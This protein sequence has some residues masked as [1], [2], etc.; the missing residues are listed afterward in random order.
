M[1]IF[2]LCLKTLMLSSFW[3][4]ANSAQAE[5]LSPDTKIL[6]QQEVEKGIQKFMQGELFNQRVESGIN[7]YIDKQKQQASDQKRQKNEMGNNARKV[8]PKVDH[9]RGNAQA[10]YTLIEY[11]DFECPYCKRFH[12]TAQKFID[13][14]TDVNW[15]FRN[16]PLSFHGKVAQREAEAAECAAELGG[17][18]TYWKYDDG[19]FNRTLT[20]GRGIPNGGIAKLA[21]D[22]GLEKTAFLDC[23]DSGK[24]K[25]F[26]I[27]Q[28]EDGNNAGVSGTPGNLLRHNP[29]GLTIPVHGAQPL[30]QL[31]AAL[32]ALRRQVNAKNE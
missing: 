12:P 10:N 30:E 31:Q 17:N 15:V 18:D 2:F 27:A 25:D 16:Y 1:K 32:E 9:I 19:Q 21:E 20:N 24:F 6:I 29:S 11:S 13:K 7:A 5:T 26:V 22:V 8:D 3:V 28:F 23:V 4:A 14:N